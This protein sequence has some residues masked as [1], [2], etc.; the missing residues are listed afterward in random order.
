[1]PVRPSTAVFTLAL[2]R[3]A[4]WPALLSSEEVVA[5]HVALSKKAAR[6]IR[7]VPGHG[8]AEVAGMPAYAP[9]YG[10]A[11]PDDDPPSTIAVG[12]DISSD[13]DPAQPS[14]SWGALKVLYR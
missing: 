8:S 9:L 5:A 11:A 7:L 6:N 3:P 1:M 10:T 13:I 14:K 12:Q 2:P 4:R